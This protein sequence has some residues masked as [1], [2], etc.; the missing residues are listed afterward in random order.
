MCRAILSPVSSHMRVT[1]P[2]A[3]L[4]LL[5]TIWLPASSASGSRISATELHAATMPRPPNPAEI[6]STIGTALGVPLRMSECRTLMLIRRTR[7]P[8]VQ[9]RSWDSRR[10]SLV[11]RTCARSPTLFS[12]NDSPRS[13]VMVTRADIVPSSSFGGLRKRMYRMVWI[14]R[15]WRKRP[16]YPWSHRRCEVITIK[17]GVPLL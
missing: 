10:S 13:E 15:S 2:L 3:M 7:C 12:R 14:Q 11:V 6:C 16:S 17:L 5:W 9:L 8:D 4:I 1:A